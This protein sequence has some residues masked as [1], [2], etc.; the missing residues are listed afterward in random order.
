M[1]VNKF[2]ERLAARLTKAFGTMGMFY[3]F[4]GYSLLPLVDPA[5][6]NQY[7]L[8]SNAIQMVALPLLMVG[9]NILGRDSEQRANETHDAVMES[10]RLV[11]E[12]HAATADM[13]AELH[14][15]HIPDKE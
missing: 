7:L 5:H 3:A 2:N 8:Y 14:S 15:L 10:L 1:I 12:D 6:S 13:V 11:R 4:I 9:T